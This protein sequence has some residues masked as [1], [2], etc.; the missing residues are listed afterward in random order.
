MRPEFGFPQKTKVY[1]KDNPRVIG[2]IIKNDG[3][4]FT[5]SWPNGAVEEIDP[6]LCDE[7]KNGKKLK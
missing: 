1:K 7:Y 6:K 5:I 4:T 2:L 3:K